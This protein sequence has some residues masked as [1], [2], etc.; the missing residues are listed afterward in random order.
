MAKKK[1]PDD[2]V[3]LIVAEDT[4]VTIERHPED[5]LAIAIF[6]GLAFI[7]FAQFFTRYVLNDSLAWTEEIARYALIWTVF[8]GAVMVTRRN[9]HIA[10]EL[11][12]NL[13]PPT[14]T[15]AVL[16]AFIDVVKLLFLGLLAYFSLTIVERMH[17]QRMTVIDLPMSWVYGGV[18]LGCIG[19]FAR[20]VHNFWRNAREHWRKPGHTLDHGIE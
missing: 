15:R 2:N 3:H 13:L 17:Y 10:V 20:Q 14:T 9:R 12:A 6:W 18:V 7:V 19:M 11:V 5:W 1:V 8:V 16:L 4:D